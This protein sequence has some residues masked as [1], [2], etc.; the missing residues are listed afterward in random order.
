VNHARTPLIIGASYPPAP[1]RD[2]PSFDDTIL[3]SKAD[4]GDDPPLIDPG[5]LAPPPAA[6]NLAIRR[7]RCLSCARLARK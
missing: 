4:R 3:E 7:C 6:C 5:R 2:P 1:G